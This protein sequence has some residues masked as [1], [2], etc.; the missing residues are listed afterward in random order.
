MSPTD[1][2]QFIALWQQGASYRAIAQAVG[3]ALSTVAARAAVL[4]AQGTIQPRPKGGS[5]IRST[6]VHPGTPAQRSGHTAAYSSTPDSQ[7]TGVHTG[8]PG[9]RHTQAHSGT[10][11][12]PA[13]QP[14]RGYPSTPAVQSTPVHP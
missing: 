12:L 1:E 11:T 4:Q 3:C 9:T 14:T 8:T 7:D 10:P 5:Q 6:A 13:R 2:A